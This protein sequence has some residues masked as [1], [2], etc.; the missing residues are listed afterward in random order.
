MMNNEVTNVLTEINSEKKSTVYDRI[1]FLCEKYGCELSQPYNENIMGSQTLCVKSTCGH[2]CHVSSN[3][4]VKHKIGTLYCDDCLHKITATGALC[5]KCKVHFM[6][7]M[8][9]FLFC[10]TKCTQSRIVTKEKSDKIRT[11]ILKNYTQYVNEDGTLKS[12]EDIK[13]IR[14]NNKRK[15]REQSSDQSETDSTSGNSDSSCESNMSKT[16]RVCYDTIK[17]TYEEKGCELITT[18]EEYLELS[19]TFK[20]KNIL[21]NIISTCGHTD[22]SL[23]YGFTESRTG[24][25]CKGCTTDNMKK[26]MKNNSI[27]KNGCPSSLLTQ[28]NAIDIIR[29]LCSNE[30]IVKKTRDGCKIDILV[31]PVDCMLDNWLQVKL[32]STKGL[33]DRAGF[34]ITQKLESNCVLVMV[35]VTSKTCWV[36]LP[37][38]IE[39]KMYYIGKN[40][41]GHSKYIVNNL[42][43]RLYELYSKGIYN[44]TIESASIPVSPFV[45]LEHYYVKKREKA[46]DFLQFEQNECSGVV[47]NF[48]INTLKV[49]ETVSSRP[50]NKNSITASINKNSGRGK[51]SPY[52]RGDNN[53]YWFNVNDD[54]EEFYV[55]PEFILI[56]AGYIETPT[57]P[58]RNYFSITGN[59]SWIGC[60]K[61]S[62][63]TVRE[64]NEKDRLL[65]I[66]ETIY[67]QRVIDNDSSQTDPSQ[68]NSS[69]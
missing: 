52:F 60:Y 12:T 59:A 29:E 61:F 13:E 3:K 56:D 28:K 58:G 9:S 40:K 33:T 7:T 35:C 11:S 41:D 53:I 2:T 31:K 47:Y 48:T 6:P 26:T 36:I 44:S 18:E 8:K 42:S 55:V 50:K 15:F 45:Q 17:C 32:K 34:R 30:L 57:S 43:Q 68:T 5:F 49:Q 25:F 54:T 65:S 46:I 4:F 24:V 20:L 69:V 37:D 1:T 16:K 23:Y 19:K 22:T 39:I 51:R 64:S 14:K 67:K 62:Y 21:F 66:L 27:G 10:S 38:E 63:K